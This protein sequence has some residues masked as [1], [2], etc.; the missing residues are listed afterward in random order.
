[1]TSLTEYNTQ[2]P[3]KSTLFSGQYLRNHWTLGI[4]VLGYIGIVWPKEHSPE[5]SHIPPVTL[6]ILGILQQMWSKRA[7]THN[8]REWSRGRKWPWPSTSELL[9]ERAWCY[10]GAQKCENMLKKIG[11]CH[12]CRHSLGLVFYWIRHWLRLSLEIW[13]QQW[14]HGSAGTGFPTLGTPMPKKNV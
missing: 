5:V 13:K 14:L 12:P 4:G 1:M 10:Y 8:L 9:Y 2:T 11:P 3:K 7:T 6:C